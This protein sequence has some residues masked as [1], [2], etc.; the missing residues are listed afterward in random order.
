M[1]NKKISSYN[2]NKFSVEKQASI[3]IKYSRL[4]EEVICPE[5]DRNIFSKKVPVDLI[6]I[7]LECDDSDEENETINF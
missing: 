3:T 6:V 4:E 5:I 2:Y 1:V 7:P